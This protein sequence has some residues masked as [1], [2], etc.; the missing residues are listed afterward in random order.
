MNI[1]SDLLVRPEVILEN[2]RRCVRDPKYIGIGNFDGRLGNWDSKLRTCIT[3][4]IEG[5]LVGS[6]CQHHNPTTIKLSICPLSYSILNPLST[7]CF[8]NLTFSIKG[9]TPTLLAWPCKVLHVAQLVFY[10]MQFQGKP[11]LNYKHQIL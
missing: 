11:P 8:K 3:C 7:A 2:S 9:P 6:G 5:L 1:V 10:H 4:P